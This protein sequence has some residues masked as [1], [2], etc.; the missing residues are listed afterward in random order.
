[1]IRKAK[2][3]AKEVI[4]FFFPSPEQ[5]KSDQISQDEIIED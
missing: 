5:I 2:R 4:E 3:K 1:M